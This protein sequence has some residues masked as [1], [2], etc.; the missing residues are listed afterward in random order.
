MKT[1]IIVILVVLLISSVFLNIYFINK[2][3]NFGEDSIGRPKIPY[4]LKNF[5]TYIP[6]YKPDL[7]ED[8]N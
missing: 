8:G 7:N 5:K 4:Y 2:E 1:L 6:R 3:L